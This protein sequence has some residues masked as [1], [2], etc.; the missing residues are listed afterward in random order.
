MGQLRHRTF[1]RMV[2]REASGIVPRHGIPRHEN[3]LGDVVVAHL[4]VALCGAGAFRLRGE[5][6]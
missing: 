6:Q 4:E 2:D 5:R 1:G 3:G